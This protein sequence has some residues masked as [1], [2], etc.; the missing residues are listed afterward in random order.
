MSR[1]NPNAE[2]RRKRNNLSPE[3]TPTLDT[4]NLYIPIDSDDFLSP[5]EKQMRQNFLAQV[6]EAFE[7][8]P[9]LS[10]IVHGRRK[11]RM[12]Q[13]GSRSSY[14]PSMKNAKSGRSAVY[15]PME[16]RLEARYAL[17]LER[18]KNVAAFRT[19]S[20]QLNLPGLGKPIFPDFMI[21]DKAGRLFL[22]DVKPDLRFLTPEAKNRIDYL[23]GQLGRFGISYDVVDASM[24]LPDK[25]YENLKWLYQRITEY[26][27]QEE[28]QIFLNHR[29]TGS[30]YGELK[31]IAA[32]LGL[33][34]SI[35]PYLLFTEELSTDW[36][37]PI[38][39]QSEVLK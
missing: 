1:R 6:Q 33:S 18:D 20:V 38:N 29:F 10:G 7:T 23:Q 25:K 28:I 3:A 19:Q 39:D 32:A 5:E 21:L 30:T 24:L 26:P 2:A 22:R 34:A 11:I 36:A 15:L 27:T 31:H 4:D 16:S 12:G 9:T 17:D 14:F 37:S 35:V 13:E 8:E